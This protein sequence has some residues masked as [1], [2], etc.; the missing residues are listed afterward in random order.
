MGTLLLFM[1]SYK[2]YIDTL[3][4]FDVVYGGRLHPEKCPS[5]HQN[6]VGNTGNLLRTNLPQTERKPYQSLLFNNTVIKK[7]AFQQNKI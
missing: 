5:N 4:D 7:S 2:K 1:T 6:Y 3:E